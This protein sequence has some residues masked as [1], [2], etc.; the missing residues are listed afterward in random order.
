MYYTLG[1]Y[2]D[3]NP[4]GL[5]MGR[6]KENGELELCLD[7]SIPKYRDASVGRFL[8]PKLL[9]EEGF[10]ALEV[11]NVSDKHEKYLKKVGFRRESDCYRLTN[12]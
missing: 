9:G 10:S 11:R 3:L 5:T 1:M 7:Y 8:Y 2:Y 4:V 6:R 12:N